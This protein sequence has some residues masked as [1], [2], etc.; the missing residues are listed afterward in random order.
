MANKH[1]KNVQPQWYSHTQK[2]KKPCNDQTF[3]FFKL[4]KAKKGNDTQCW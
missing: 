1:K 4:E 2:R 3:P